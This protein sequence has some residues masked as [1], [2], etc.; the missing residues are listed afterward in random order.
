MPVAEQFKLFTC[1]LTT[2]H[3]AEGRKGAHRDEKMA[4]ID[5]GKL[6]AG[7]W[8]EIT[9]TLV[10]CEEKYY[11]SKYMAE[12]VNTLTNVY[13]IWLC[14]FG[15]RNALQQGFPF[16][17]ALCYMGG[18]LIGL[19]SFAFHATLKYE[20][21]LLD[22]LPMIYTMA[23]YL[24]V[25]L[26]TTPMGQKPRFQLLLPAALIA[27]VTFVTVT[28]VN[29]NNPVFHQVA[30][31]AM[32]V[33]GTVQI[34]RLMNAKQDRAHMNAEQR[35]E[36]SRNMVLGSALFVLAFAVWNVDN[37]FCAQLRQLRHKVGFPFALLLEGHGWWHIGTGYGAYMVIASSQ[38]L[39][40]SVKEGSAD[41]F[42][43]RYLFG[44]HPYTVRVK[45]YKSDAAKSNGRASKSVKGQ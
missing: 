12:P 27:L 6:P 5:Q 43:T 9:S 36:I 32:Q 37:I 38:R 1:A 16:R 15:A 18:L 34:V 30:Y 14:A 31:G 45:P 28:Y 24:Y 20:A 19:G 22:E 40:M 23:I 7:Y 25:V 33:M 29:Y 39:L 11:F 26:E 4:W 17:F 8:G 42:A 41:N 3:L 13:M 10:W 2:T 21:Q 35:R 44:I